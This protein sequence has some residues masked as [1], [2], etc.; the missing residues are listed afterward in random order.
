MSCL[1]LRKSATFSQINVPRLKNN[2]W[3][4]TMFRPL[5]SFW[6]YPYG[7]R[8]M[9][10]FPTDALPNATLSSHG[11]GVV[12]CCMKLC[13]CALSSSHVWKH[14]FTIIRLEASGTRTNY[15]GS[16]ILCNCK[17]YS[18]TPDIAM[19]MCPHIFTINIQHTIHNTCKITKQS[20]LL[21]WAHTVYLNLKIFCQASTRGNLINRVIN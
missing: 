1:Q 21:L 20:S 15:T 10:V 3:N 2:Y 16:L 13:R 11:K 6:Y 4:G 8:S 9:D 17:M 7:S 14:M 12:N 19:Q 18:I 5:G